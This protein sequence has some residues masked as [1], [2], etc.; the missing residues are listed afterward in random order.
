M[1][2]TTETPARSDLGVGSVAKNTRMREIVHHREHDVTFPTH[3]NGSDRRTRGST[4]MIIKNKKKHSTPTFLLRNKNS[5]S[6]NQ[7]SKTGV[8][9][10]I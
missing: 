5:K 4:E 10:Q 2:A 9:G 7:K 8:T 6:I 1:Y 3:R